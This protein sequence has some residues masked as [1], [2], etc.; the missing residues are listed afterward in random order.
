MSKNVLVTGGHGFIGRHTARLYGRAGYTV[1]GIGH[2]TWDYP[3]YSQFG[4]TFWHTSDINLDSLVTYAGNPARIIRRLED[5][6]R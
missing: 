6:E 5:G 2:G 1:S 4:I 3:E